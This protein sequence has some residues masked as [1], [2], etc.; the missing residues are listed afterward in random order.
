MQ[1]LRIDGS[2]WDY[3]PDEWILPEKL[4]GE[5]GDGRKTPPQGFER[6][7]GQE[8]R[9]ITAM[10][11]WIKSP[12]FHCVVIVLEENLWMVWFGYKYPGCICKL[13]KRHWA[14]DGPSPFHLGVH[15]ICVW[16]W[17]ASPCW[18]PYY[19]FFPRIWKFYIWRLQ[20]SQIWVSGNA[21]FLGFS[22]PTFRVWFENPGCM[23]LYINVNFLNNMH[24]Y[25]LS[26]Y[27]WNPHIYKF[28]ARAGLVH[29]WQL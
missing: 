2:K 23:D 12:F 28:I 25:T 24:W 29:A 4:A 15:D 22:D 17:H 7:G 5:G 10:T 21:H 14:W 6:E 26:I 13:R 19:R 8:E 9:T 20:L 1:K 27:I 18:I 11:V 16:I 3:K